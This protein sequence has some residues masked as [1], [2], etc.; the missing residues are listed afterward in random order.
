MIDELEEEATVAAVYERLRNL[1]RSLTGYYDTVMQAISKRSASRRRLARDIF[2][3]A[4]TTYRPLKLQELLS[5]LEVQRR[6]LSRNGDDGDVDWP[7]LGDPR[8]QIREACFP[9]VEILEDQT[10]QVIHTSVTQYLLR[11]QV[12][13][14]AADGVP[15][16][17][18]TYE[19]SK[20]HSEVA[21]VAL[22]LLLSAPG[23]NHPGKK[24]PIGSHLQMILMSRKSCS[25]VPM[26]L[27]ESRLSTLIVLWLGTVMSVKPKPTS[28][29]TA[30]LC[31]I[32]AEESLKPSR[33]GFKPDAASI[34]GLNSTSV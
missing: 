8:Q 22:T 12:I 28:K 20:A 34:S 18:F 21:L 15:V 6:G 5:A 30:R 7:L 31:S 27:P 26:T 23:G 13:G 9:L 10:V 14:D 1:P 19:I 32:S 17:I 3:W 2:L 16:T 29:T 33:T 11:Q 24:P 4:I 25:K